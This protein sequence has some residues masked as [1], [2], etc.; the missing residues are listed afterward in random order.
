MIL[1]ILKRNARVAFAAITLQALAS[2]LASGATSITQF[3][4]TWTFDRDYPSGQFANGDYWVVGPVK[5]TSISPRSTT[6]GGVTMHGSMINPAVNSAQGYDSRI[7]NN[8]FNDALNVAR[9]FPL[10]VQPGSS[11]VSSKSYTTWAT[12]DNP[13]LDTI[14]ILT[15]LDRAAP[16]GSFRP[17]PVGSD[18]SLRWNKSQLDYS[19]LRSLP[20]VANTPSLAS[21]EAL[22]ERPWSEQ[23]TTWVGRYMHAGGNQPTYG[24]EIAHALAKGLLS[25]Q[26][27][28][29][30]AQKEKLLVRM[31]QYGIDVYGSARLG[32]I[33]PAGGG[34][35]QGRKMPMLLA[36]AVLKDNDILAHADARKHFRFQ[37]DRQTWYVTQADVGRTLYTADG[38]PRDRYIQSDVGLAEWGEQHAED[39][40]RDG[41]NW[42]A[43]YR[44]VAGASIVGH[45]LTARLMGLQ[46]AWNWPATFDYYDRYWAMENGGASNGANSIQL[47]VAS[48]WRAYRNATPADIK[49]ENVATNIWENTSIPTQSGSFTLSFDAMPSA[50]KMDGVI[51]F[52]NG[53]A[54]AY[55]DLAGA[56]RF[57]PSGYIDVRNGGGFQAAAVV[58]Y[59]PGVRYHFTLS[60]DLAAKR[61]SVTV[62][63]PG[64]AAVRIADRYQFRTEQS[65]LSTVNNVG[66]F[67]VKGAHAVL[68]LGVESVT[69]PTPSPAPTPT[70]TP[71]PAP[72]EKPAPAPE[73]APAPSTGT[74]QIFASKTSSGSWQ[75]ASFATFTGKATISFD[76]VAPTAPVDTI[77]GISNG[78]ASAYTDLA[79][80]VRFAPNGI[81]DAIH[82]GSWSKMNSIKYVAG[83]SYRVTLTIDVATRRYSATVTPAGGSP[84][85]LATEFQFRSTQASVKQLNNF[86]LFAANGKHT[87][88]DATVK[89]N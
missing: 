11:L 73:P 12:G 24:R 27:N 3:G 22:F 18:K 48:M 2:T 84:I 87:V 9:S 34:H 6:S 37:E 72:V 35:N 1:G 57:A 75:N 52:S 20:V 61:Y 41:R 5:I 49:E 70:P 32:A 31:V 13:Q 17:A 74:G 10:V 30:N 15:V 68:D 59:T 45:V 69:A 78:S 82:S 67:A 86:A 80:A 76:M 38:R 40:R 89:T 26:L 83:K 53:K 33:W 28:Y 64:A 29:T 77:T 71:T 46:N 55:T 50:S 60:V 81:I 25:L 19:K 66:Y 65:K 43:Y 85:V 16:A 63:A 62:A 79:V 51:G 88:S 58:P 42:N 54:D 44:T 47:Q 36:G 23:T 14:A 56:V 4:I 21:V 8:T 39:P 7:K